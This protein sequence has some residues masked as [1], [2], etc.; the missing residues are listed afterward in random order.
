MINLPKPSSVPIAAAVK[1][2]GLDSAPNTVSDTLLDISRFLFL[3]KKKNRT[4]FSYSKTIIILLGK[5][6][7]PW[8]AA[9]LMQLRTGQK[10]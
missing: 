6:S 4:N 7:I 1:T 5:N 9:M 2:T 8:N 3:R 10:P